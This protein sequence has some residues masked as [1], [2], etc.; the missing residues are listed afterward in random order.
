MSELV[1]ACVGSTGLEKFGKFRKSTKI[2]K[3]LDDFMMIF[4]DFGMILG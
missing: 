4:N 1:W 3:F 2:L